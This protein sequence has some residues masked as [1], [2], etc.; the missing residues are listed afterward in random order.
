MHLTGF[1]ST[2][3]HMHPQP[4]GAPARS[5][6]AYALAKMPSVPNQPK[7]KNK[8]IRVPDELWDEFGKVCEDEG[9]NRAADLRAHMERRVRR[10][11]RLQARQQPR[12]RAGE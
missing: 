12:E 9:T 1:Q 11:K 5:S 6:G 7:N 4:I 8:P 3:V 10:W 2:M